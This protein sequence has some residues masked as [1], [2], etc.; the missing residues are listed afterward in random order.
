[1]FRAAVYLLAAAVSLPSSADDNKELSF[2][3]QEFS[4]FSYEVGG[5]AHGPAVEIVKSACELADI[6]CRVTVLPWPR[7]QKYVSQ[8]VING[9]F[10][11]GW[12]KERE[13][14]L[15]FSEPVMHTEY[16]FFARDNRNFNVADK[17]ELSGLVIAVYGPSNTSRTLMELTKNVNGVK[18]DI[19]PHDEF[20]F[21]KLS[22]GRVDAVYS[23]RLVGN[24][25]IAKLGL[26]N[27]NY[28][29]KHSDIN[30]YIGLSKVNT[31]PDLAEDYM[32]T[33]S[34]MLTEGIIENILS[35]YSVFYRE[36][37]TK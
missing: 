30:Y 11:I 33:I 21:K 26:T 35:S 6:K 2:A 1:M 32:D 25:L 13:A 22:A 10:P 3:T 31:T 20:P 8:G 9:F 5:V 7:A 4:P 16:G 24:A 17:L 15:Y 12:S 37:A 19:T 29:R 14:R 23:N 36:T 18:L 34:H 28:Y 27:I